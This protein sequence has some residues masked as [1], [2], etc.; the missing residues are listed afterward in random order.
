MNNKQLKILIGIVAG[1]VIMFIAS[2]FMFAFFTYPKIKNPE[3]NDEEIVEE[4]DDVEEGIDYVPSDD[5]NA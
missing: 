2:L 1:F 3:Q 4:I 5:E